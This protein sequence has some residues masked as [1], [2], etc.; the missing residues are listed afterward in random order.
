MAIM[1]MKRFTLSALRS[2]KDELLKEL[3][4][5]GCVEVSEIESAVRESAVSEV[6]KSEPSE[7]LKLR[8]ALST[9]SQGL[10]VLDRY[11]PEK[12]GMFDGKN[13]VS[14]DALLDILNAIMSREE[15]YELCKR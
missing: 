6:L 8:D 13:E 10:A 1:R 12:K 11:L 3:I 15:F 9:L 4:K 2:E 5:C 14:A 7:V